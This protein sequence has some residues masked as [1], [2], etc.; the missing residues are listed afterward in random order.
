MTRILVVDDKPENLYLLRVLLQGHGCEVDEARHGAEALV[1]ARQAPPELIISD[2]LMPVMDGYTLLRHWKADERLR[3]IP[4]VV[5]TA[6]YTEPK[7]EQLALDLGADAFILK[8]AEPEP[9]VARIDEV[10]AQHARREF[11]P[12][13]SL[14]EADETVLKEYSEVLIRKLEEKSLQLEQS[15]QALLADI[16]RRDLAEAQT[17]ESLAETNRARSALLGILEDQRRVETALRASQERFATMFLA[18]PVGICV[19]RLSDGTFLN[20]NDAFLATIGYVREEIIGYSSLDPRFNY[21]LEPDDRRWLVETLLVTGSI[22][23][24]ELGF[25]RRDGTI[26]D[27]LRSLERIVIDGEDCILTILEDITERKQMEIALRDSEA[28]LVAAEVRAGMGSW[29]LDLAT[30]TG[31]WSPGMFRLLGRDSTLGPPTL[32]EFFE[33]IHPDDR[34][35]TLDSI[36]LMGEPS[37]NSVGDYRFR[38]TDGT[39]RHFSCHINCLRDSQGKTVRLA[40]SLQDITARKQAEAALAAE[41]LLLRTMADNLPAFVFMKDIAGRYVFVNRTHARQLGLNSEA[42]M[43]GKTVFEMFPGD[44]AR[45]FDADDQ[46]VIRTGQPVIEREELFVINGTAGWFLTTKVPLRDAQGQITGLLGIALDISA[47]KQAEAALV[48]ERNLLR[49]LIDHIPDLIFVKDTESRQLLNNAAN[50]RLVGGE[51]DTEVVGK[52]VFDFY[53]HEQAQRYF[54]EDQRVMRSGQAQLNQEESVLDRN[55]RE[56]WLLSSKVPLRDID[57]KCIGLVGIKRDI[58]EHRQANLELAASRERLEVL[59]RQLIA[60]QE[61]E[62]RHLARELH[63]EIGQALTGIKMNLKTLQ[64]PMSDP[65]PATPVTE[66]IAIVDQTLQ[67]VRSLALELRPSMLDDIGI[68]AALRWCLDRQ[69]RQ[70]GFAATIH[71]GPSIGQLPPDISI[72]CFRVAQ[73]SFTNIA[74]HAEA[75]HVRVEIR[76][77]AE[78]LELLVCD[79]GVGFDVPAARRRAT[80]GESIGLL[81][82]EERIQ[83]VGGQFEIASSPSDGTTIRA[84][85]PLSNLTNDETPADAGSSNDE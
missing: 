38:A 27:S 70:A 37:Q 18:S 8:P 81:G 55:G 36:S 21:W 52:T 7:D 2:L 74:R 29:E 46:V 34:Q 54:D 43:L 32:A 13:R 66:A 3:S 45:S 33:L 35:G 6:T 1:K 79:D 9:F 23:N 84:R 10:L 60:T 12:P 44:I 31:W 20:A 49:T 72:A 77:L 58:T 83:L 39:V 57:G 22:R 25:R 30:Q 5:Y 17:R 40:G 71:A 63:D 80:R 50:L 69:A 11:T 56:R 67:Q 4:F 15:N 51:K 24:C 16:A 75:R 68:V 41:R 85:F 73:E 65:E 48:A 19:S 47:R 42:E 64:Q 59:S 53:P 82:M 26:G 28:R 61:S 14:G 76:Q 78:E 62:R